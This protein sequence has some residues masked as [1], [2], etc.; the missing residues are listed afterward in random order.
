MLYLKKKSHYAYFANIAIVLLV[1]AANLFALDK[2]TIVKHEYSTGDFMLADNG[3]L[4]SIIIDANDFKGVIRTAEDLQ[5]DILNVTGSEP[6]IQNIPSECDNVVII[7]TIGKSSLIDNLIKAGRIDVS[8]IAGK[9]ESYI[10]QTV[11]DPMSG[12]GKAL[13]IA[14]SDKRG[15][16][17]GIYTISEQIGVSPWYWWADVPVKKADRLYV[18]SG[19]YLYGSPA[20]KYRGVFLNDEAPA[21]TRW[22][23]EKFGGYNSKFYT[24][25]FELLL[26]L[27]ANFLWPAMWNNSFNDDDPL[28][29]KLADEYGIVIST[30]HH[31]PMMRAWKEWD[32]YK[33]K[34]YAWDYSKNPEVL[35]DFWREGIERT[36]D[37]E[38]IITLAMRGD[39]DEPMTEGENIALLENVVSSQRMIL[40]NGLGKEIE[41]IPQVWAL[42][43]EVQGY[44]ERGMR[45][46]DDVTLL[47]CDDN[48]GNI[49][50]LP[51]EAECKRSGGAG[52]YY[53]FDYVG[54]PRSYRWIN[55]NAIPKI[56]EQMNLA[57]NYGADR[58]WIVNVGDLKPMEY[59]IEFFLTM[60]WQP[61]EWP[62]ETLSDYAM[63]WAKREFGEEYAADIA[64]IVTRYTKYN[65]RCKPELLSPDTYSLTNYREA[66]RVLDDF[67]EITAK[68]EKIYSELLPEYQ[69]SFFQLVLHPVKA[70]CIMTELNITV[71][72]NHL[73]A[74]QGRSQTNVFAEKA[75][76]L[77]KA[78]AKLAEQYHSIG[79]GKWNHMMDQTH[80]GYTNW[81]NPPENIMPKV[82]E[83][84]LSKSSCMGVAVGGSQGCSSDENVRVELPMFDAVSDQKYYIDVFN[85]GQKDYEFSVSVDKP[86]I[87]ISDTKGAVSGSV[88]LWVNIN[89][90]S[91]ANG[92]N[93]GVITVAGAGEKVSINV[94]AD[95]MGDIDPDCDCFIEA[96]G[97][98][99]IEPANFTAK[100]DS[101]DCSWEEI[102]DYGIS[103]SAMSVFPVNAV[104]VTPGPDSPHLEYNI[105][106]KNAGDIKLR[107]YLSSTLN[108]MPGRGMRF[109]VSVDNE[110]PQIIEYVPKGFTAGDGN[111]N[112]EQTVIQNARI[113][114]SSHNI[115]A[116]GKH[117]LKIWMV[118]PGI[119]LQKLVIDTGGLRPCRLGPPES[120][121]IKTE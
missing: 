72:L 35:E 48:W 42:Y 41:D 24:K 74:D 11:D 9:W 83:I 114:E 78:D 95:N 13:V 49:R 6:A 51:T 80:I 92:Q 8:D 50:R 37:Y 20:V 67:R 85:K 91:T 77:F 30:S 113:V 60:A 98:V 18:K 88:R 73:Y 58:I 84:A 90:S 16:I 104:S 116:A 39:G 81:N 108:F 10:I 59:P 115:T 1:C 93:K 52:V 53:H 117:V 34:G 12:I 102:K 76:Q 36:K 33:T 106:L 107:S 25:V 82:R 19:R 61:E 71:G 68:A 105:Y 64:E 70:S 103:K 121:F 2:D 3:K 44:Y 28:N 40:T 97:Y 96:N 66:E 43:K 63:L 27:K 45:V 21:L 57:Y 112:W 15:T 75:R 23:S 99:S 94:C 7:G 65:S 54:G 79:N 62:K 110:K 14:G 32:P 100:V 109:A 55:T 31:E 118:D 101:G 4:V 87:N 17:Y 26:R 69:D 86:W 56:W 29:P 5:K 119:V 47:W 89:W 38:K 111:R 120:V 46:P 22:T